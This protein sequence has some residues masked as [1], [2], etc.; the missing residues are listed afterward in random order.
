MEKSAAGTVKDNLHTK[1]EASEEFL[2]WPEE[3]VVSL[4]EPF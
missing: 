2:S 4:E 3:L 1:A